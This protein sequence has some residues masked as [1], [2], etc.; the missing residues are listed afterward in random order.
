MNHTVHDRSEAYRKKVIETHRDRGDFTTLEDGTTYFFPDSQCG[1]IGSRELRWIANELDR[2]NQNTLADEPRE[3][4][5]GRTIADVMREQLMLGGCCDRY[6]NMES[7]ECLK[8]ARG[9]ETYTL[10]EWFLHG[11]R[12]CRER[13]I[14]PHEGMF[15]GVTY[16]RE[17]GG[18]DDRWCASKGTLGPLWYLMVPP[19]HADKF[20]WIE[21][22]RRDELGLEI[23]RAAIRWAKMQ[24]ITS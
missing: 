14:A 8:N 16:M 21:R 7:C 1:A 3:S 12:Y 18:G 9:V 4:D 20:T 15:L 10:Q 6:A 17:Y 22:S 23:A 5:P 11:P 13:Q 19:E 24:P 2:I